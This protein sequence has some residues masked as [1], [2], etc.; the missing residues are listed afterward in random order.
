MMKVKANKKPQA[1]KLVKSKSC[2]GEFLIKKQKN[3]R[4]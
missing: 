4:E 3:F 1:R 2:M